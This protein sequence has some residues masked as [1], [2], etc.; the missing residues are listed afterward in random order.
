MKYT[1]IIWLYSEWTEH[2]NLAEVSQGCWK[3]QVFLSNAPADYMLAIFRSLTWSAQPQSTTELVCKANSKSN[4]SFSENNVSSPFTPPWWFLSMFLSCTYLYTWSH[5][6]IKNMYL[7]KP[8]C[9]RSYK[10]QTNTILRKKYIPDLP[11]LIRFCKT[12]Y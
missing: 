7:T 12:V 4:L 9:P 10:P 2:P 5:V 6:W 1:E 11:E 3:S 8:V